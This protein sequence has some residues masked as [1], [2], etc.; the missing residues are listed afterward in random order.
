MKAEPFALVTSA[1][2]RTDRAEAL[3]DGREFIEQKFSVSTDVVVISGFYGEDF[4]R[5]TLR[6]AQ[7]KGRGRRLTFV[8]AGL[9]EVARD[10]QVS[11]LRTLKK[12]IIGEHGFA[13]KN[14]D[15]R[16]AAT[17]KFLHAKVLRFRA[18]DRLP[19]YVVGSANFSEAAFAQNDEAMI[20]IRGRHRGLNEYVQ[21]V[22]S[23]S[24]S[25]DELPHDQ[26]ARNWRNFFRNGYLYYRPSRAI[27]Y[28]LDPFADEEFKPIADRLREQ[29]L[30][31]LPFSDRNVLS[32]NVAT[33]LDLEP[34]KDGKLG[35]QLPTYAV[36]TD[37]GHWAPKE[38]VDFIDRKL[39]AASA[40][41]YRAL[42]RR[43]SELKKAGDG[44]VDAQIKFYLD[45]VDRRIAFGKKQLALSQRQ[46]LAIKGKIVGRVRHLKTLLTDPKALERLAQTLVGAPVPEFWEDR[47]SVDRFFDGFSYDIVAKLKAPRSTPRIVAHL[48]KEFQ[49]TEGD[50]TESCQ[51]KIESFFAAG[52]SWPSDNWPPAGTSAED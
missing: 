48:A 28:T 8:F 16:L 45:E 7:L 9:A 42:Q 26:P 50:D 20:V 5:Q 25:I 49:I 30:N 27:A 34:P 19:V 21:H 22:L 12:Y 40:P 24:K 29:I 33:L 31:P 38:Y 17:T 32:L 51:Q 37:Y 44:Y 4:I 2:A 13:S 39:K 23:T 18:E 1:R 43:G 6:N 15:I 10:Q 11:G 47:A 52:N 14:V 36:E 41:K 46:K 3:R 35:F